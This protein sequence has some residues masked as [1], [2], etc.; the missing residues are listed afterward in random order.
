MLVAGEEEVIDCKGIRELSRVMEMFALKRW[1][2][3]HQKAPHFKFKMDAV[4][5]GR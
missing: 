5:W 2:R 4:Y 1:F 3:I